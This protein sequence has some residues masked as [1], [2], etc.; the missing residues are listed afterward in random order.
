MVTYP[1]NGETAEETAAFERVFELGISDFPEDFVAAGVG[2]GLDTVCGANF[3]A[4]FTP[5]FRD[6]F[7]QTFHPS[8]HY[9][10]F[11]WGKYPSPHFCVLYPWRVSQACPWP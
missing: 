1:T 11:S 9:S 4:D 7:Q 2:G 3:L 5:F 6:F 10:S 8:F